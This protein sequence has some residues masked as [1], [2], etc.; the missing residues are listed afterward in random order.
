[1]HLSDIR[2]YE[3]CL[4]LSWLE[5][6]QPKKTFPMVYYNENIVS[7]VKEYFHLSDFYEGSVGD[8]AQ[9][10]LSAMRQCD[11]LIN[12]RFSHCDLRIHIPLMLR[13]ESGWNLYFTYASCYPRERQA[14]QLADKIAVAKA[15][16]VIVN[17]VW[18]IHLN[19]G[20]IRKQDLDVQELL[21]VTPYLYNK[22][23]NGIHT[24]MDLIEKH[25]RDV[26]QIAKE[27]AQVLKRKCAKEHLSP[28]CSKGYKCLY[29]D[30]CI[31]KRA[32]D[33]SVLYLM[34]CTKKFTLL[35]HG[36]TD[37]KEID[38][39]TLEGT[40]LQYAQIMAANGNGF[41]MDR[42]A[43]SN[44]VNQNITYP[45]S[46]LDF[47]WETFVYPPY[48]GMK[49]FDVLVFQYSLHVE[50]RENAPLTHEEFI[51]EGDCRIEF[52][53][54][55]LKHI[56]KRGTVLVYNMEGAEK[57]R[58]IQLGEQFPKYQAE[59]MQ[60]CERMVDLSIPFSSGSIYDSKMHGYY[61]LKK[62]VEVF[63]HFDYHSLAV[64]QG[65]QAAESW[66]LMQEKN[67]DKE[68]IRKELFEYCGMDTYSEYLIFHKICELIH[69]EAGSEAIDHQKKRLY[70][71]G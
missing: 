19:A 7:L 17:E 33:T 43:L 47:E 21:V 28:N 49:P 4:R 32:H 37:M 51:G 31:A 13:A 16:G 26:F 60:I 53:E 58:L 52:I 48:E 69:A 14:Q 63:C 25:Q 57:L 56:P 11:T 65:L 64:S 9:K 61:S 71:N 23:N 70:S 6:H 24:A 29:Y 40:R 27:T 62:L 36:V 59:L 12:A 15:C 66:R 2:N 50:E 8:E 45:I 3:R 44:W 35:H 41:Y 22:R 68:R 67:A 55:L 18:I 1:M 39:D 30:E 38:F 46:Y 10:A 42:F 34:Q 20:Y 54:H 5:Y